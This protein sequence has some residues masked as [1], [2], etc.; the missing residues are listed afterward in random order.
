MKIIPSVLNLSQ[1]E[2][3]MALIYCL[4][5]GTKSVLHDQLSEYDY[6]TIINQDIC[7]VVARCFCKVV[8]FWPIYNHISSFYQ[9][10]I[11][12]VSQSP[13]NH[14]FINFMYTIMSDYDNLVNPLMLNH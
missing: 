13:C 5:Y 3:P 4:S 11:E 12:I 6:Y 1:V 7:N 10:F 2:T 14:I 9:F 8:G